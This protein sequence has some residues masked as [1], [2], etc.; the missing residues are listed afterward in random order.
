MEQAVQ[1]GWQLWRC[2]SPS[3]CCTGLFS[4]GVQR[5]LPSSPPSPPH[6]HIHTHIHTP[7]R[8]APPPFTHTA[9]P[10]PPPQKTHTPSQVMRKFK[11]PA[12]VSADEVDAAGDGEVLVVLELAVA[13]GLR[14]QGL[15]RELVNR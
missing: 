6:T 10:C 8:P 4:R 14:E 1:I 9:L 2:L 13:E 3:K 7:S 15:A 5:I 11:L 12:G